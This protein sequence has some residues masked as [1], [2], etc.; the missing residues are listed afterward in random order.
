MSPVEAKSDPFPGRIGPESVVRGS[1]MRIYRES[2][3]AAPW[4]G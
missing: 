4:V 2:Q 3:L 1:A